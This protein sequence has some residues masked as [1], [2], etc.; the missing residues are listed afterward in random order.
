MRRN[1]V[2]GLLVVACGIGALL[3]VGRFVFPQSILGSA[4]AGRVLLSVGGCV[5]FAALLAAT[6]FAW[7]CVALLDAG[8]PA[9]RPWLTLAIAFGFFSLGQATLCYFQTFTGD[10]PFPSIAD[11]W[12]M[13]A[14]PLLVIALASFVVAY[15]HSGFPMTG[16]APLA[17]VLT[18][19]AAA[20]AWPLLAPIARTPAAPLATALNL[21]YPALDLL[22]L[23][24]T[25]VLLGLTSRFRGGAVWRIW[26][27]LVTGFAFTAIGDIAFAYFSTLNY[28]HLDPLTHAM[29]IVAYGSLAVGAAIQYR[30]LAPEREPL[31][32]LATA[33]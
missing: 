21:A 31:H 8:N 32:N 20:V 19:I 5:K 26:A 16:L 27:A 13:I 3:Q 9:R 22:L 18:M 12:F 6:Y 30:I 29:Y 4:A 10:S 28:T 24:P 14:Y 17:T 25:I 15:A 11:L 33:A 23:V 7:R 1:P 2:V